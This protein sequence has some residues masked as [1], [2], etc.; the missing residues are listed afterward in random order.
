[1]RWTNLTR[2]TFVGHSTIL[3]QTK[4]T[5]II[6]DPMFGKYPRYLFF[7]R[8]SIKAGLKIE[9]LPKINII[10]ISHSHLDH[11]HVPSL[12]KLPK[13]A[14]VFV[15]KGYFKKLAKIGF[16]NIHE[17]DGNNWDNETLNNNGTQIKLT[18]IKSNH[19]KNCQGYIIEGQHTLYFPGDT[20][21]FDEIEDISKKF[22][23]DVVFLPIMK[24]ISLLRRFNQHI[25]AYQAMEFVKI[26]NPKHYAI[27]I[28]WGFFPEF[29]NHKERNKFEN[30]MQESEFDSKLL[31]LENGEEIEFN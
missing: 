14:L 27:P 13:D 20:G 10:L 2:I 28:H 6:T 17:L 21:Y 31:I 25:D 12:K 5:N 26:L 16:S 23:I 19:P 30:L 7:Y 29:N 11:F 3:I 24:K 4:D 9:D 22:D 1:M 8:R 18:A 15:P